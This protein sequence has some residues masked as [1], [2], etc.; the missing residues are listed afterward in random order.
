MT[1]TDPEAQLARRVPALL[2]AD[3]LRRARMQMALSVFLPEAGISAEVSPGLQVLRVGRRDGVASPMPAFPRTLVLLATAGPR[4][5]SK[6]SF[7]TRGT[8]WSRIRP[9]LRSW[10]ACRSCA[11]LAAPSGFYR[12][13]PHDRLP[14]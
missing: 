10:C 9:T 13:R 6:S 12:G 11:A 14:H 2:V 7:R 8:T 1:R 5:R 4:R 3:F